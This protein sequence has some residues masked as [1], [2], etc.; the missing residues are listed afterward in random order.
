VLTLE[1]GWKLA[2]GWYQDR[3]QQDWKPKTAAAIRQLFAGIG[4]T[5]Q[6]W[7]LP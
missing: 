6:F 4:L 2:K 1:Q 3:L 7:E 5:G